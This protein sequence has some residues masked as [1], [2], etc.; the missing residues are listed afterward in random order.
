[1]IVAFV[2]GLFVMF[3]LAYAF[4]QCK[5]SK[6]ES[7][8]HHLPEVNTALEMDETLNTSRED[9]IEMVQQTKKVRFAD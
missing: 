1:M 2:V 8:K 5:P 3:V 6:Q 4:N 7:P 9:S